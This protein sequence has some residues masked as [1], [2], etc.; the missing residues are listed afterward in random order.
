MDEAARLLTL[1]VLIG[2]TLTVAG[3]GMIWVLDE[4]RR[5]QRTLRQAL[6][7]RPEPNLI[8]RGRGVGIG[9]DLPANRVVVVWDRGGWR[10]DYRLEELMGVDL[11]VDRQVAARTFRG[12]AR[13]PLDNLAEPTEGVCLR[14]VFDDPA[15]PDFRVDL[16]QPGDDDIRG[17]LQADDALQ[18]GNRWIARM[19]A[20]LR[21][22]V[23]RE[24]VAPAPIHTRSPPPVALRASPPTEPDRMD[25]DDPPWDDPDDDDA[26]AI[27]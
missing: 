27:T 19:E 21:R 26:R 23:A 11:I 12:E 14:F 7:S 18:E 4:T 8:V 16:W 13:R 10:L 15:H 20:I 22:P 9:F 6:G 25:G 24:P 1:L 17:R 5:I 3:A 2:A